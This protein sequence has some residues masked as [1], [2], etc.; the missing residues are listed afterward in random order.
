MTAFNFK[1]RVGDSDKQSTALGASNLLA[2][3]FKD[4]DMNKCVK[5]AGLSNYVLVAAAD[6]LEGVTIAMSPNMVNN[7]FS[8]GTIANG[9]R[10]EAKIDGA[11]AVVVGDLVLAGAQAALGT[12]QAVPVVRKGAPTKFLWRVIDLLSGAGAIGTNV[13]IERI[14]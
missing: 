6:E 14:R 8:F 10:L 11:S 9:G 4:E 7:G 12:A 3:R 1:P 2:A 13:I 5:L